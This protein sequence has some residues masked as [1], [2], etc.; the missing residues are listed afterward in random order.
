MSELQCTA[1][2][3][4]R[5][6]MLASF[7]EARRSVQQLPFALHFERQHAGPFCCRCEKRAGLRLGVQTEGLSSEMGK[8]HDVL[9]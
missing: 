1:L 3:L 2:L 9:D 8:L 7:E 4:K 6:W 5:T